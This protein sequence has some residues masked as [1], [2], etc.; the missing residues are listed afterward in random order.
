MS[1]ESLI[2]LGIFFLLPLLE[3]LLERNRRRGAPTP[4][5]PDMD[6]DLDPMLPAPPR[7][8]TPAEQAPPH[9]ESP[10]SRPIPQPQRPIPPP[11]PVPMETRRPEAAPGPVTVQKRPAPRTTTPP[12]ESTTPHEVLQA[13]RMREQ[14]QAQLQRTAAANVASTRAPR[15]ATRTLNRILRNPRSLRHAILAAE[16]LGPCKAQDPSV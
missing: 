11:L 15:T 1:I 10:Q 6:A 13:I 9:R 5:R 8:T 7:R 12:A 4:Q 16:V 3:R 2:F 14:A